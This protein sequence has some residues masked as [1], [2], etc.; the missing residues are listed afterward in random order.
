MKVKIG[1]YPNRWVSN[2][3]TNHMEKK[4]GFLWE[5]NTEMDKKPV[6][7]TRFDNALEVLEDVLQT[8]YNWTGNLILD[9][10]K[11]RV[12]VR[13]DKW[14]TW[15][16]DHTLAPI[17]HPMLVQLKETNHG[18]PFVTNADVPKELRATKKQIKS[19]GK[20]GQVDPKHFDRWNWVMD[21]MIWAF[22]QKLDDN[23]E[24]KFYKYEDITVDEN[25]EDFGERM[26]LKLVWDNNEGRA[27]HQARMTNGFRLFGVY[28]E[29]LW[30]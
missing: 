5:V 15:S 9:R 3:H 29:N 24:S 10:L 18:A 14:D 1:T 6:I 13:I 27:A 11:Q 26:G 19:Y 30:D 16:M 17:I 28:F 21:E 8:V 22:E 25:S 12:S 4:Y 23:W 7:P 2:I 20:E